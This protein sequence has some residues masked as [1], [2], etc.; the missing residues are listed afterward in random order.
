MKGYTPT[1]YTTY[2][3]I[4]DEL[5]RP[6]SGEG[7]DFD[8]LKRLY[9]S[10]LVYLENLRVKC[11]F[12]MNRKNLDGY[13]SIADYQLILD[14]IHRTHSHLRDLIFLA[15]TYSLEARSR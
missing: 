1:D 6:I 14:A 15:L 8:T 7:L 5:L 13:F 2:R 3:E 11:F 9:E 12:E 10:K 4:M